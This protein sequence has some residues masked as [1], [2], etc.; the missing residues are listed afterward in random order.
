LLSLCLPFLPRYSSLCLSLTPQGEFKAR[1]YDSIY[2]K[3]PSIHHSTRSGKTKTDGLGI[4][5]KESKFVLEEHT[6]LNYEDVHDRVALVT[7]LRNKVKGSRESWMG[8]TG[9]E[10]KRALEIN[11]SRKP[12]NA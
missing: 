11:K 9:E 5:Y 4:F 8:R 12:E 2:L 6:E 3:R 7:L 1:G 10:G